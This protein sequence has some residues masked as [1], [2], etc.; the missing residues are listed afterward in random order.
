MIKKMLFPVLF[1]A[2]ALFANTSL[3]NNAANIETSTLIAPN[4][5]VFMDA[6]TSVT[7]QLMEE[8]DAT[9]LSVGNAIYFEVYND[10]KVNGKIVIK[11][12]A[13]A[14]GIVRKVDA[15]CCGKGPSLTITVESVETVD[16]QRVRL[17][18]VPHI[19]KTNCQTGCEPGIIPIGTRLSS[20]V[21]NKT[22][23]DA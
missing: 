5:F 22:K 3:A 6:G 9:T 11:S 1:S 16:G 2:T 4:F 15:G 18:S 13:I 12:G 21:L 17:Q 23:I 7:V 10:V 19:L 14:E 8:L 20:R